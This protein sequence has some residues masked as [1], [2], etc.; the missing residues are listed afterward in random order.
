MD[1]TGRP[2]GAIFME[3]GAIDSFGL[4]ELDVDGGADTLVVRL[5]WMVPIVVEWLMSVVDGTISE[6]AEVWEIPRGLGVTNLADEGGESWSCSL[7][8]V[9]GVASEAPEDSDGDGSGGSG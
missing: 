5:W 4:G 1:D 2:T 9:R 6:R 7:T 3:E 8:S